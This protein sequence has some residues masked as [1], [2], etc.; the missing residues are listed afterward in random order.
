MSVDLNAYAGQRVLVTGAGGFIGSHVVELLVAQGAR[1]RAFIRYNSRGEIGLLADLE[2]GV[3][4]EV[5]VVFGDLRD[6]D[7]VN[8][9]M[10]GVSCVMHLGAFVAIPYSYLRPREVVETNVIGTLN[11][12]LAARQENVGRVVHTSTSEVYGTA[13]SAPISES[14]PIRAQSPYAASKASADQIAGSFV[15]SYGLPVTILRP[16]NAYGPRQS[17]RAVIPTIIAQ[18]L[19]G[20]GPISLGALEPTRD[21]TFVEDTARAFALAGL[22]QDVEGKV[23]NAGSGLE[24]SV[25]GLCQLIQELVGTTLPVTT[26]LKRVRPPASEVHRLV[27]D[28][29]AAGKVLGWSPSVPLRAGLLRTIRWIEQRLDS[30]KPRLNDI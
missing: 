6:P 28:S 25:G 30:K 12:L 7:A 24:I 26:D 18:C 9:A 2:P 1:V 22:A 23:L 27:A 16:F 10:R 8:A 13:Q 29:S 17:M 5:E 21:F 3:L 20:T 4:G 15:H 19:A 11:V 14:H